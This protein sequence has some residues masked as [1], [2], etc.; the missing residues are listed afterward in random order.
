[1]PDSYWF[2]YS[3]AHKRLLERESKRSPYQEMFCRLLDGHI[4]EF[5]ILKPIG[6]YIED[7]LLEDFPD[8]VFLGEGV[9]HHFPK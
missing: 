4:A 8:Y 3:P 7:S 2:Y 5:I 1:M 9:V 6:E